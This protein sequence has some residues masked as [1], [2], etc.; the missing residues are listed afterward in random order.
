MDEPFLVLPDVSLQTM[1]TLLTLLHNGTVNVPKTYVFISGGRVVR[2]FER[3]AKT[4][5]NFWFY[6]IFKTDRVQFAD[7]Q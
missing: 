2:D 1:K 5:H 4:R 3:E 7:G 6:K